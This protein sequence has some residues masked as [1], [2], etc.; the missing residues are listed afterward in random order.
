MSRQFFSMAAGI[1]TKNGRGQW[2]EA[3]YPLPLVQ[4]PPQLAEAVAVL[5][6][7]TGGNATLELDATTCHALEELFLQQGLLDHALAFSAFE[8]SSRPCLLV[9]LESDVAPASIPEAYLKLHLLSHRLVTPH[10]VNLDGLFAV[11]PVVAWT[12]EGA[13]D[14]NE[15][16]MRQ[17]SARA[18]G[19]QL[20]VYSV[21]KFPKMANYVVPTGVRIADTARIR[22]GAYIGEGTTVMHEGFVNF[23]AGTRGTCM[24]EGRISAGVVVEEDSD[25]G[26]GAST[27]GVLSGGND[28]IIS[29]GKNC[30]IGANAGIGIS[31][32]DGCTVEAGLYLTAG[33]KVI[34]HA[35]A[36]SGSRNESVRARDL[37]GRAHLLFR[38]NS[39]SGAIECLPNRKTVTLNKE[40]H[41]NSAGSMASVKNG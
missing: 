29:I 31:L 35:E 33:C 15:L 4:P 17:I 12:C 36:G 28:Q 39:L 6:G 20:N 9:L 16:H 38:R 27:M 32:G 34:V 3:Y 14:P 22:L 25:L 41:A 30:L 26:G 7:Y 5:V 23:N 24:V 11:L 37:S 40:L 21:D 18:R 13:I 2:L 19:K 1:G 10:Q 8:S